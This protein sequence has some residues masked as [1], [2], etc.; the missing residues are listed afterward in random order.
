MIAWVFYIQ[1]K[2]TDIL[3]RGNLKADFNKKGKGREAF[4]EKKTSNRTFITQNKW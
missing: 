4:L 3:Q 1:P 2:I